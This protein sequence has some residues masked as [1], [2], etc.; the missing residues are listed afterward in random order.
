MVLRNEGNAADEDF[1]AIRAVL[2]PA[3]LRVPPF[4]RRRSVHGRFA[5]YEV[6][7]EGYFGLVDLGASYD[8]PPSTWYEPISKWLPSWMLRAGEVI[9]V[10]SGT[11]PGVPAIGRWQPMPAPN[12]AFMKPRGRILTESKAGET[13]RMTVDVERPCYAFIKITYFPSLVATV[14]GKRTR[15]IR[16]FPDFGA[17]PL[18]PGHHEVEVRYQPGPLK[19]FLFLRRNR[20][21]RPRRATAGARRVLGARRDLAR[22]AARAIGRAALDRP[23][24]D[25]H[26]ARIADPSLHASAFPGRARG[27]SRLSG[28]SRPP[29]RIRAHNRRSSISPALGPGSQQRTRS[30]AVRVR[31]AAGLRGGIAIL[32]I[33]YGARRTRFS[34]A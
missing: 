28:L 9:A 1:F 23:R 20:D 11:F 18:T 8:G 12:I 30:A 3:T 29:D 21:V 22:G 4:F 19:P 2:A 10:N 27:R 33:R 15:L 32:Q 14:D 31:S 5:V 6:S 16:V 26:R 17:I 7:T 13:Y 24:E 25:S 34:S